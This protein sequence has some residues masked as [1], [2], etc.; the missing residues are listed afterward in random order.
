MLALYL[1]IVT[2]LH[3]APHMAVVHVKVTGACTAPYIHCVI[4]LVM[5][6]PTVA[7]LLCWVRV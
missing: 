5:T 6:V 1:Y 4:I 3:C 2:L 7:A